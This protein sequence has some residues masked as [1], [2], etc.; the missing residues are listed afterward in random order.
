MNL[1]P[2]KYEE[3]KAKFGNIVYINETKTSIN[4]NIIG[5]NF[6]PKNI[7]PVA[8]EFLEYCVRV[9]LKILE[10]QKNYKNQKNISKYYDIHMHLEGCSLANTNLKIFKYLIKNLNATFEDIVQKIYVHGTHK[11]AKAAFFMIKPFLDKEQIPKF[12][13]L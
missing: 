10:I 1:V 2:T 3:L 11:L 7:K 8:G 4:M 6:F 13:L 12:V 5:K 9:V